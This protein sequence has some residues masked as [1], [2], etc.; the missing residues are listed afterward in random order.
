[1]WKRQWSV[2]SAAVYSGKE[3]QRQH[4]IGQ[5]LVSQ[6]EEHRVKR[7]PSVVPQRLSGMKPSK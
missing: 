5:P 7:N 1:M 6:A 3:S 4:N 2:P